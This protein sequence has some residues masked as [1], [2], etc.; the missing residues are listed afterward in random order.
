[1]NGNSDQWRESVLI[2]NI[3]FA[4][5]RPEHVAKVRVITMICII[6]SQVGRKLIV[7]C[8]FKKTIELRSRLESAF[9]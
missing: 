3:N 2:L 6:V 9:V 1:M 4:C 8:N 7:L 5:H